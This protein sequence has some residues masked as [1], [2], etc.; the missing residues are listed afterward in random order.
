[1]R[2]RFQRVSPFEISPH[3]PNVIYHGSQYLHR[4]TNGGQSWETISPDLTA[5]EPDKQGTSGEPITRDITGEEVYSTLYAIKESPLER[6]VIWTGSNDGPIHVTRDG[7]KT[8]RNVTPKGLLPG[9]RVQNIEASPHRK[10][11]AY[12]ALYRYLLNDWQPYIYKTDD[13]G[14]TWTRLSDGTNGIPADYPTRVVREDPDR[15]GLLYAGTEFGMF[16]SFDDG[17]RWQPFQQNLPVTPVT[18]I[19]VHRKDLVI[20]TMGRSFWVLDDVK[21]LQEIAQ[22]LA[23]GAKAATGLFAPRDAYRVRYSPMGGSDPAEPNYPPA[24]AQIDYYLAAEPQ[25]EV[26]LEILDAGGK[27]VR[28][29]SSEAPARPAVA[30][31]ASSGGAADETGGRFGGRALPSRLQKTPGMHRFVWD[32]RMSGGDAGRGGGAPLVLPGTY[33]VRFSAAGTSETQPLVVK[34]DPRLAQDGITLADLQEQQALQLKLSEAMAAG[35][36]AAARLREA[37][38]K[39]RGD[40]EVVRRLQSLEARLVTAGGSYPQPMLIDQFGNVARMIGQADQK[41]GRDA[42]L[43]YDDL[44]E[45]LD[46][47]LAEVERTLQPVAGGSR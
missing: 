8:W 18:D 40:A 4:T 15:P 27:T 5:N 34:L 42:F 9:G 13:Y 22:G 14:L 24:G 31:A 26:K 39:L 29:F 37:R 45:Q 19:K 20:S 33:Q 2:Y 3:D 23:S 11:G 25:G 30:A 16:V 10:G 17:K 32:L 28:S 6:G 36:R 41:V 35:R 7:G 44:K 12:V 1:M 38:E 43:R 47:L 46:A 21:P